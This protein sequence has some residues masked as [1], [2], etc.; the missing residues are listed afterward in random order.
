M[1]LLCYIMLL[2]VLTNTNTN[3]NINYYTSMYKYAYD[4]T[5]RMKFSTS[6]NLLPVS[7]HAVYWIPQ[8]FLSILTQIPQSWLLSCRPDTGSQLKD[9]SCPDTPV[10]YCK[11]PSSAVQNIFLFQ[12]VIMFIYYSNWETS[13]ARDLIF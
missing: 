1:L 2:Y 10:Q 7:G 12:Y 6:L 13:R 3:I 11:H 5:S 8:K 9:R 4:T